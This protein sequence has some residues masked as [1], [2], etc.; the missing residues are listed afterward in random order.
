MTEAAIWIANLL[1][2]TA[3]SIVATL[4][5]AVI[6]LLLLSGRVDVS[7]TMRVVLGCFVI[8]GA[9]V[10]AAGLTDLAS[11]A[12]DRS[13]QVATLPPPPAYVPP[14]TDAGGYDPYAGAA[15]PDRS[16]AEERWL[17]D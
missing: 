11:G 7:R 1:T 5:V 9:G 6:G 4:A 16:S 10:I 13:A 14:D 12:S 2:G 8:F 3:A 17:Q 15:V